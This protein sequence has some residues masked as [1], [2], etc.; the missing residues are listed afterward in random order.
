MLTAST[1]IL[2]TLLGNGVC[3][4]R[5]KVSMIDLLLDLCLTLSPT[6]YH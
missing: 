4:G 2:A 3:L 6:L 5:A 1:S